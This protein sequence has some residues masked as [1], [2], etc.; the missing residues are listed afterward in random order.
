MAI[1]EYATA[2]TEADTLA[3]YVHAE[4]K[5]QG[6]SPQLRGEAYRIA[7]RRVKKP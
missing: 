7:E 3:Q 2:N 6:T 5:N 4:I 1:K